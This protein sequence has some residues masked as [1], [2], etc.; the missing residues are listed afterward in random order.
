MTGAFEHR[1]RGAVYAL[2]GLLILV[3][4]WGGVRLV[5]L[6]EPD[7]VPPAAASLQVDAV[8][9][10]ASHVDASSEIV[11]RPLFWRSRRPPEELLI[12]IVEENAGAEAEADAEL[13]KIKLLGVYGGDTPGIIVMYEGK[14]RRVALDDSI[15]SWT[16]LDVLPDGAMFNSEQGFKVVDLK[17]ADVS[18]QA[19]GGKN[20]PRRKLTDKK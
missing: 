20:K 5:F 2:T 15:G 6:S 14:Q 13:K 4:L 1:L 12:E 8:N 18:Q 17:H 3:A 7:P 11:Q 19:A 16:L 10:P 9:Y